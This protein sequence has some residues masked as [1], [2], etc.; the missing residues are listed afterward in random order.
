MLRHAPYPAAALA[1]APLLVLEGRSLALW[2]GAIGALAAIGVVAGTRLR[3]AAVRREWYLVALSIVLFTGADT[4]RLLRDPALPPAFPLWQDVL[5][6][7]AACALG[8]GLVSLLRRCTALR[9][10]AAFADTAVVFLAGGTVAGVV[11]VDPLLAGRQPGL[12]TLLTVGGAAVVA[13][14]LAC[15]TTQL[16]ASVGLG[17]DVSRLFAPAS[18][19]YVLALIVAPRV[20]SP[21]AS[22]GHAELAALAV[23]GHVLF[24]AAALQ[25]RMRE[26]TDQADRQRGWFTRGRLVL[27][28]L[29][30]LATAAALAA[31]ADLSDGTS[32][33][34]VGVS[35]LLLLMLLSRLGILVAGHERVVSSEAVLQRAAAALAVAQDRS[36]I[37]Q[38]ALEA[39]SDLCGG[40]KRAFVDMQL[41]ARP[42]L[43][44]KDAAVVGTGDAV[45]QVRGEIRLRGSLARAGAAR[46]IVVPLAPGGR[47]NG[48]LRV[49][50]RHPLGSHLHD[51]L[52]AL[53][54]QITR[55]LE[56][57]ARAEVRAEQ[58][59]E[60]RF[61]SLV[62][63]SKDVI[64]V[65]ESDLTI[66]YVTPS[67]QAVLGYKPDE[68]VGTNLDA[69]LVESEREGARARLLDEA[70]TRA[71]AVQ[72]VSLVGS[73]GRARV[74]EAV[75]DDLRADPT[76][77]GLVLTA[78]D[79]TERHELEQQLTHQ[80]FHDALT[81]LPNRAL[82]VDRV[83]H[84][85]HHAAR[86]QRN[87]A[88]LFLDI[89]DF[90][91]IND[92]LGHVA[93]DEVLKQVADALRSCLR[94]S[95]TAARLGGDEF[96]LLLEDAQEIEYAA[97]AVADRVLQAVSAPVYVGNTEIL[98]RVSIGIVVGGVGQTADELLRSADVA[99][100]HAK[101]TGGGR[102]AVFA[103][104]MHQ[105]VL[106]RLELKADLERAFKED[107]LDLH[108]QPIV[109]IVTGRVVSL[110]ALLRWTHPVRGPISP[111]EFIPF[112]EETGL[113]YAIGDWVLARACRDIQV[114]QAAL[115]GHRE[116]TVNVNLSA[117]QILQP[118]FCSRVMDVLNATG[119]TSDRL[120]LEITESTLMEDVE[121]VSLRLAQLRTLG[122]GIAIDD[123]G[124]GFS[125]LSYLQRF[126]VD[127]LKIAREFVNDIAVDPR[128]T[129]LVDAIVRLA[130]S[131]DLRTVAEGIEL[132]LQRERLASLGCALGQGYL[133]ARPQPL[134]AVVGSL[135]EASARAA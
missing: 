13:V 87:V 21:G 124:T 95:D 98:V 100:Y 57:V 4:A 116:L 128:T 22:T 84:A 102:H 117:R 51:A 42:P 9:D 88:L 49:T 76:V 132:E 131:L 44:L 27:I 60:A 7:G 23:G 103:P 79:V 24:A 108:Y 29:A 39:A 68:L 47:L 15:L 113:I 118:P 52:G 97:T 101:H 36:E 16:F 85:L 133:F 53:G 25:P 20:L 99:M 50:G 119:L 81:G 30:S 63:N 40:S 90:K 17:S 123:F 104:E 70:L 115:P 58:S 75:I 31:Y 46:T 34:V 112:A 74:V 28:V 109:E 92:S 80:A 62:Q 122:V 61:R 10:W 96:A 56:G 78:H 94:V 89:D 106:N 69:L 105:A 1:V 18:A 12:P 93:G 83:T 71:A 126:P 67:V 134:D 54:E 19:V 107:E 82:L 2:V 14:A 72:D 8:A 6:I 114:L 11:L 55:S 77:G 59:S 73:D 110:E 5:R 121:G 41:T 66:R 111:A 86:N 48:I 129:R 33:A 130:D 26:L 64:C 91:T 135:L 32:A 3:G 35:A 38:A 45:A 125:S 65:L 127:Q 120:M 43:D 37:R